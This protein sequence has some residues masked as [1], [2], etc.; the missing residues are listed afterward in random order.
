MDVDVDVERHD[1]R[2]FL[3]RRSNSIETVKEIEVEEF[4]VKYKN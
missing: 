1:E 4:Y 3:D 2:K